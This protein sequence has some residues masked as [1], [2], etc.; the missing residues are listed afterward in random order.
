MIGSSKISYSLSELCFMNVEN[1]FV[2]KISISF[3]YFLNLR[4]WLD[5][6]FVASG[7]NSCGKRKPSIQKRPLCEYHPFLNSTKLRTVSLWLYRKCCLTGFTKSET[8]HN[9]NYILNESP[10]FI[11]QHISYSRLLLLQWKIVSYLVSNIVFSS[12]W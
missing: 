12:M 2:H 8:N 11:H 9:N 1:F 7:I 3:S 4:L 10:D 6:L 5:R